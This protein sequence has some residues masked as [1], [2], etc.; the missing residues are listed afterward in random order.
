MTF[1]QIWPVVAF[2]LGALSTL[3]LDSMRARR[4][5]RDE[6]GKALAAR[7]QF[8]RDRRDEFELKHLLQVNEA[9]GELT[10][11]AVNAINEKSRNG[12]VGTSSREL[13]ESA[14]RQ[15]VGVRHL[16]LDDE[17]RELVRATHGALLKDGRM[18]C[19]PGAYE[20]TDSS[21]SDLLQEARHAIAA[22]VRAIYAQSVMTV[23]EDA[24]F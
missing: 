17:L 6:R 2:I 8:Y 19:R 1:E 18:A 14:N 5:R 23:K 24:V 15:I 13:L 21:T 16:I 20:E 10:L 12:E 3:L 9:L 11:A 22:R 7:E 4:A